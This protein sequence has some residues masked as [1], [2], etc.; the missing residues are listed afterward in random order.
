MNKQ[1][2]H[3]GWVFISFAAAGQ[4]STKDDPT[5]EFYTNISK[6]CGGVDSILSRK[7]TWKK[8]ED[9]TIFPDKTF[10]R[11][12]YA[13]LNSRMDKMFPLFKETFPDLRGLEPRWYRVIDGTSYTPNGAV[14]YEF[15]SLYFTYYC[16][17]NMKKILLGDETGN[18]VYVFIN[19]LNWFCNKVDDWDINNDGKM[20]RV[21]RLPPKAGKWKETWLYAPT[22]TQ[23]SHAVIIAHNGKLPWHSLTQK[24]YLTGLKNKCRADLQKS[25]DAR[26]K[27][28]ADLKKEIE[29]VS[30]STAPQA[31]TTKQALEEQ[32]KNSQSR[33]EGYISL[34]RDSYAEKV[35]YI[36][37]YIAGTSAETLEQPAFIDPKYNAFDFKGVFGDENNGGT[38]LVAV[39]AKYF[40]N[41]LP[42]YVP[43][44]MVL[45]WSW[46]LDPVSLRF[47]EQFEENFPL[48]KLKAMIDK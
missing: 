33:K 4:V 6:L 7:G 34:V 16:N 12:Q 5:T 47:K 21:Y 15:S 41:D 22:T 35:K 1:F 9:A 20:I 14:P 24:Q 42:R 17:D 10:P 29:R 39:G 19:Q 18:W 28:E 38:K 3:F 30:K 46:A 48:E 23:N 27:A 32:L 13:Q 31:L 11:N 2:L 43:Q 40:D 45:Y 37:D 36:D 8:N 44:F 25:L 26:D